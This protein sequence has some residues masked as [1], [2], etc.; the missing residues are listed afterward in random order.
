METIV[1]NLATQE[2]IIYTCDP[3]SAVIAAYAQEKNDWNT[4]DYKMRYSHLLEYGKHTV[5][6]GDWSAF[7]CDCHKLS[8]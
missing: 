5:L 8:V 3:V 6:C 7:I 2:K 4:W 1:L